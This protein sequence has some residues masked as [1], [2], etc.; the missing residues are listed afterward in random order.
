MPGT[1]TPNFRRALD[2]VSHGRHRSSVAAA[3]NRGRSL[4]T[5]RGIAGRIVIVH[6]CTGT[7]GSA[8]RRT[9]EA[10][11][12]L[13]ILVANKFWYRRGGQERVLF[14]EIAW[15]EAEGHEVA[16]FSTR[17]PENDE[18]PWSDYFVP[19]LEIGVHSALTSR[20][21]LVAARR[22]FW[23]REAACRFAE[24]LRAFR[25]DVVHVH[26][27]HHQISPSILVE[28]RRAHVPVVQTL[29]DHHPICPAG[30]LL[31]GGRVA[32]QPPRCGRVNVLPCVMHRCVHASRTR[33][34]LAGAELLWRRW[35]VR[36]ETLVDAFISPSRF[37]A[38]R[39]SR[40][41]FRSTPMHVLPNAVPEM[42]LVG[43]PSAGATFVYAGRLSPEK[44]LFTL[45]R[46]AGLARVRLVVA[47]DGP[48]RGALEASQP[49]GVSF[50]GRLGG[51]EV[52]EL[53][54]SCRA[55]VIPSEC[56]ENAPMAVLEA[57]MLGRPVVATLL[58]GIPEQVRDGRDGL[59]VRPGDAVELAAALH[60]LAQDP[61]LADRMGRSAHRRAMALFS[62]QP[63][64]DGLLS[65]YRSV[66]PPGRV[67]RLQPL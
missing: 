52:D 24:L 55:A 20:Q 48:L 13:R 40:V 66:L 19:Y 6:T 32:C 42:S 34:M 65:I 15:L 4:N 59:L 23:N 60:L 41:A 14:D 2:R 8:L 51:T 1:A 56:L 9:E 25:P 49:Q 3:S 37:L 63:H 62:P 30:T 18:S 43:D 16:H 33:S 54:Q 5:R 27:I 17:H 28:A 29:H 50:V 22:L 35:A 46:A 26:G 36:Y 47:G 31:L 7:C 39:I 21:R 12:V 67:T 38:S 10:E 57:M 45:L 44:G 64:T 61:H 11:A 58:G 53:L